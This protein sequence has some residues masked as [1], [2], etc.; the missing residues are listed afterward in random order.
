M[1]YTNSGQKVGWGYAAKQFTSG[2]VPADRIDFLRKVYS[3]FFLSIVVAGVGG[4][5]G[6]TNFEAVLPLLGWPIFIVEILL[7]LACFSMQRVPGINIALLGAFSMISG[8]AIAPALL[9][10]I[11]KTGGIAVIFQAY[12]MTL[13]CFGGITA[14]VFISKKDFSYLGGFLFVALFG[15][16]LSGIFMWFFGMT[17]GGLIYSWITIF[18]FCGFVLFDTSRILYHYNDGEEIG[19]AISL[20]LDFINIFL[21]L[22]SIMIN[23]D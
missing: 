22:L 3:Y 6:V 12:L 11:G 8:I 19:A 13:F 1:S 23:R 15:L 10:A 16:I 21:A 4:Y 14:Y 18:I 9:M 20:Y 5:I 2:V 7:L 17:G